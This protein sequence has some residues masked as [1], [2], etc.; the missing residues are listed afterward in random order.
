[1]AMGGVVGCVLIGSART[2]GQAIAGGV[3]CGGLIGLQGFFSAIVSEVTPRR[4]R[5]MAQ[6]LVNMSVASF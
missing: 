3:L 6:G 2:I 4:Y 5:S 1:M